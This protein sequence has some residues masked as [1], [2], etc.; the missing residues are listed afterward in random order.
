MK[1]PV[2]LPNTGEPTDDGLNAPLDFTQD[3]LDFQTIDASERS[4]LRAALAFVKAVQATEAGSRPSRVHDRV[5]AAINDATIAA[6]ERA[7]RIFRSDLP[8][9][10]CTDVPE[11]PSEMIEP[12]SSDEY[13][14][15]ED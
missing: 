2:D 6:C 11:T 5:R 14:P 1:S 15:G 7:S 4:W 12:E 8:A 13:V 9:I 10:D 3:V